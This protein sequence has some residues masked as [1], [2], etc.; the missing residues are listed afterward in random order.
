MVD[1]Q[2]KGLLEV[3][4]SELLVLGYQ[5]NGNEQQEEDVTTASLVYWQLAV[6]KSVNHVFDCRIH[7]RLVFKKLQ[8]RKGQNKHQIDRLICC[9]KQNQKIIILSDLQAE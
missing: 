5:R 1:F 4:N 6:D 7:C 2:G 9:K 3:F 8:G